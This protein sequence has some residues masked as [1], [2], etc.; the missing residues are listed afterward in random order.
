MVLHELANLVGELV[1][2]SGQL[3]FLQFIREG[4]LL[5]SF[6]TDEAE[7]PHLIYDLSEGKLSHLPHAPAYARLLRRR[8]FNYLSHHEYVFEIEELG[9]LAENLITSSVEFS[10]QFHE[11][12]EE[13]VFESMN[14]LDVNY[15]IRD[16]NMA[17]T[18][19]QWLE[20]IEKI[21]N[22]FP[23]AVDGCK[24]SDL[25]EIMHNEELRAEMQWEEYRERSSLRR[26]ASSNT[27]LANPGS[28]IAAKPSE[29]H[30]TNDELSKMFSSL[31]S[32]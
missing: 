32:N 1:I 14:D 11:V 16:G 22:Y 23:S 5:S 7:L 2:S 12:F 27:S 8:L 6:R 19:E 4:G 3:G 18:I 26:S 20:S 30:F 21:E 28:P 31:K 15:S 25:K 24:M 29:H 10:E 13:A 17:S 9:N